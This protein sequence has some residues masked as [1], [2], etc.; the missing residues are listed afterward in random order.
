RNLDNQKALGPI[1]DCHNGKVTAV[2]F[3]PDGKL[4]ASG[5]ENRTVR[6]YDV[7]TCKFLQQLL[8]GPDDKDAVARLAFSL[9]G[10]SL[11][12]G[13]GDGTLFVWGVAGQQV[14]REPHS[15]GGPAYV[16]ITSMAISRDGK[17]LAA[18]NP[19]GL[20]RLWD[21]ASP[22]IQILGPPL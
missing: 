7:A 21:V 19:D 5:G 4:L 22:T 3:S 13:T 16:S 18:A 14:S 2:A 6:L 9:D 8:G 1:L 17:L 11:A 20:I 10:K 15:F 12:V